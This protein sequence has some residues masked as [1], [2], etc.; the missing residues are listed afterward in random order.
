AEQLI[1]ALLQRAA[2]NVAFAEASCLRIY[3]HVLKGEHPQAIDSALTCLRSFGIDL[4]VHPT[5]AQVQ[6]EYETVWQT[7]DGR[8]AE[9]LIDLPMMSDPE[10]QAA[11]QVLSVLGPPAY[12]S[13]FHLF[14]FIACRTVKIGMQHG[15][16]DASALGF[17]LLGFISGPVFH[18]YGAGY[19]FAKL[20]CDLVERHGF[21]ANQP[22][23]YHAMGTVA[24]WTQPV[25]A[26]IDF[27]RASSRTAIETGDLTFT[28][29][30][31]HQ[32]VTGLL[33]QNAPLDAVWRESEKAL[34]AAREAKYGDAADIVRSQQRF[35]AAMQGR[36]AAFST[37]SDAQFDEATFEAQ[38]TGDRMP[39]MVCW[40]WIL[41]LKA[42]FL[43][44]DYAEA[45]AAAGK[46]KPLLSVATAQIQLLDYFCY[47]ALTV[48]ALYEN[49]SGDEQNGWR[50]LLAA[51]R[52]QLREWA[53]TYPPTFADKY[54][55]I[56]AEIARLERRDA[57]A[58]RLYE[59]AINLARES[60][61]VQFEGLAHEL[62]AGWYAAHG[63]TTAAHAHRKAARSCYLRWGA[64]GK[65]RQLDDRYPELHQEPA[66]SASAATIDAPVGQLDVA[67]V[68]KASQAV[69]REIELG[70]VIETLIKLAVEHGGAERGLLILFPN[71]EPRIAAEATTGRGTLEVALRQ[72]AVTPSELPESVLHYVIR[73]RQSVI[74]DEAAAP[75]LFS[76]DA[77]VQQVRPRSVLCVPLIKQTKLVGTLYLENTLAPRVF[78]AA[79]VAVL[80][81]LASQAAISLENA[82]LYSNLH[83]SES[84]L[85]EGQRIS[86]TGSW[87]WNV[88]TGERAWSD[89]TFRILGY[90]V[91]V[92][93]TLE[94]ILERI[95][96][97]DAPLV[98]RQIELAS[99]EGK[100]FDFEHRLLMPDG[101]VKHIHLAVHAVHGQAGELEF[102]GTV[103]DVTAA[104]RAEEE[105]R[106]AQAELANV[107]RVTTLGELAASIAHE[108]NQPLTAVVS[109]AE[110]CRRWLNRSTPNLE[111]ARSALESI[112]KNGH[113][114]GEVTRRI[115]ALLNR[116][117]T[118]KTPLDINEVVDEAIALVH[119][120]LAGRRVSM[121]TELADALPP[122]NG[123]RIQLQQVIVNL[124]ANGVE[125]ME[126]IATRPRV[127][128]IRTQQDE[129]HNVLVA[130][131][132]CGIGI[133]ADQADKL[134][135]AFFT[136]KSSGM[137]MGLSIC[138]SIIEAHGGRLSALPNAGPGATFQFALPPYADA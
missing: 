55:L 5:F 129:T 23:V 113:R 103:M 89:E 128:V 97:D 68:I 7:L 81:L 41:K 51:H 53:E 107:T 104:R 120:D 122:V 62:A 56:R 116:T 38:L 58:M 40:Y 133:A 79:R 82:T 106:Q 91:S 48:A 78:T 86:H 131:T 69:S 87:S 32:T 70:K 75:A 93:P 11:V 25:E 61:F 102:T 20:A 59:Q 111:E 64:A 105:L 85:A 83:R 74:L 110:A 108:V 1:V 14:C 96:P 72:A 94:M 54:A 26:A 127:M 36:T 30:G 88:S 98:Q 45:L 15:I 63:S 34:S 136:T 137:G 67:T 2:S 100:G 42:R 65:V 112:I 43:S 80:E 10:L 57:D 49:A 123:D 28:C 44:G 6:G 114:A 121:R 126:P 35:I 19:R 125:A 52:E 118:P 119:H 60:G 12:F 135:D 71:G 22:K 31:T 13:D 109:N 134:F 66:A 73:T 84:V 24:F 77:Y 90:D 21:I 9:A 46:A 130:V 138:R 50:E 101:S 95:H 117:D 18:R 115:R 29:Y 92:S 16:S 124:V 17:A 47:T 4:P 3:L 37:F 132:D 8:P 33:L 99:S 39:L 76:E 27:M